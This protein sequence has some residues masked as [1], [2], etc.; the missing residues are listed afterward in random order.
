MPFQLSV[1]RMEER[2]APATFTVTTAADSGAGSLRAAMMDANA[3]AGADRIEFDIPGSGIKVI[4]LSGHLPVIKEKV[5]ID[6]FSQPG[7]SPNTLAV[8]ND[9]NILVEIDGAGRK[10]FRTNIGSNADGTIIRGLSIVNMGD[11]AIDFQGAGG[12]GEVTIQ[13]NFI[14]I[15]ADGVTAAGNRAGVEVGPFDGHTIGGLNPADRNLIAGNQ[16]IG[17]F[18]NGASD[19]LV[20]NNYVGVDRFGTVAIP[21]GQKGILISGDR[22]SVIGNVVSG[23]GEEG[24]RI[25]GGGG[26][27]LEGN[28]IGVNAAGTTAIPNGEDGIFFDAAG[29]G[30]SVGGVSSESRNVISGNGGN[31]ITNQSTNSITIRGNYIGTNAT[32]T[33]ALANTGFGIETE[34]MQVTI[35]GITSG[36]SNVISGNLAGGILAGK[37]VTILGN[38]IGTAVDGTSPLGN[39]GNG[40][41]IAMPGEVTVGGTATGS[42]NIIAFNGMDGIR[43]R[44]NFAPDGNQFLGNSIYANDGFGIHL[45]GLANNGRMP[46][47]LNALDTAN[48]MTTVRGEVNDSAGVYRVEVFANAAPDPSGA[49]EGQQFLG[50]REVVVG[51]IGSEEFTLNVTVPADRRWITATSTLT[52]TND[53]SEF[54]QALSA[55]GGMVPPGNPP[56]AV[57]DDYMVARDS[58][59]ILLAVTVNDSDPDGDPLALSGVTPGSAGGFIEIDTSTLVRYRPAPGFVG[60]ETFTYTIRDG[61]GNTAT[62]TVTVTVS[63]ADTDNPRSGVDQ[64]EQSVFAI[65][66]GNGG[67]AVSVFDGNQL[68]APVTGND[69]PLYSFPVFSDRPNPGGVRT[70]VGDITGDGVPDLIAGSGPGVSSRVNI[71]DGSDRKLIRTIEPFEASFLGG[72]YVATADLNADGKADVVITPDQGGG[73]RVRIFSGAEDVQ[74]NDFFGIEDPNFRGGAR[75]ALGDINGDGRADLLVAAG[76]TGG[77]RLAVFNGLSVASGM[78]NPAKLVGDFFVFEPTLRNGVFPTSGDLNGDR[79]SEVIVGGG[80]GGGPRIYALSGAALL[81]GQ[82]VELANFFAGNPSNRGGIRVTAKKFDGDNQSD[83]VIGS[84][85]NADSD[86]L[87]YLG[88]DIPTDGSPP[89]ARKFPVFPGLRNGVFVG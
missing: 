5:T 32:G 45:E 84:G 47:T 48:G 67:S 39:A 8:G 15:R 7:S 53:T 77:P 37:P 54:S 70:A 14:G 12:A 85:N 17:L 20:Q 55:G 79:F 61:S 75:P 82:V 62:A 80:P 40:I 9:A 18:L 58:L 43:V 23:N 26:H 87:L 2:I 44:G 49:G 81:G 6:G 71:Y 42:G 64:S 13:G 66:V 25:S 89:V 65:G 4:S 86:V 63:V 16:R 29:E 10:G 51:G 56:V 24:I 68:V 34:A 52:T 38:L 83:L 33:V 50:A 30:I 57:N 74:I 1:D 60:V 22:A 41:E 78:D 72:V 69:T 35:G 46:P 73:P 19:S 27:R 88:K 59:S 76:F 28:F 31:G 21:N 36:A 3:S 11:T